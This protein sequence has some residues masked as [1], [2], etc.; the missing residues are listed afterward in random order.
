M[1]NVFI[2]TVTRLWYL[3]HSSAKRT[4]EL[5]K[6]IDVLGADHLRLKVIRLGFVAALLAL[7]GKLASRFETFRNPL[8]LAG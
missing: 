6:A 8:S 7:Y 1:K 2:P 5:E 4:A 3:F